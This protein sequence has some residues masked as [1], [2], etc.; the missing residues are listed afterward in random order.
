MESLKS[1]KMEVVCGFAHCLALTDQGELYA[2]GANSYGQLGTGY[3]THH[4]SPV[5]VAPE[6]GKWE[7]LTQY[8]Q[9]ISLH[10][11]LSYCRAI[12]IAACHLSHISAAMFHDGKIF[13]W[14]HCRGHSIYSPSPTPYTHLDE[15]FAC[16]STPAVTWRTLQFRSR[17]DSP[18]TETLR[19]AFNDQVHFVNI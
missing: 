15:V 4:L 2:W 6:L 16:Y 18:L 14:G 11:V 8:L 1:L 12:E 5:L 7:S 17:Q 9:N 13:M 19:L 3:K 10:Y